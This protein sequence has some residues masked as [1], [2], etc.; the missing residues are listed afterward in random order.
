MPSNTTRP[1]IELPDSTELPRILIAYQ[2][3][4]EGLRRI[5]TGEPCF[6]TARQL[7]TNNYMTAADAFLRLAE[8]YPTEEELE[9]MRAAQS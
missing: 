9:L 7:Y 2:N 5:A 8:L 4:E 1:R 3:S 6:I